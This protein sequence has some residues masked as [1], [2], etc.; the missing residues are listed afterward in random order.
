MGLRVLRCPPALRVVAI[1]ALALAAAVIG[2]PSATAGAA[3]DDNAAVNRYGGCLASQKAGDLLILVDESGSLKTS[4]AH[5]ARVDA[6][7]YLVKTLGGYADRTNSKLDV[8]IAG[9]SDGYTVRQDW[10]PLTGG[11]VDAVSDQVQNLAQHNSG[12]DTDYWLALDGARQTLAERAHNNPNR[13]QAIAWFS[14]GKIDFT[15]R[16]GGRPYAPGVDLGSAAGVS[17]M[18]RRATESICRP[19]GLADQLRSSHVVMLG[20]GLGEAAS[21]G[22]FDV[23]SAI[24]TGSGANGTKCGSISDPKPGAFYRVSNI[25]QMLFAFDALNPTPGL[26]DSKPVCHQNV[27]QEARHNFVLDRSVKSVNILGSGGMPSIVPYLISPSGQQLQL[28]KKDGSVDTNIDGMPV[29]Y[30]WQSESAQTVSLR[31]AA[32]PKWPGQWAI[33]YVDT[34]GQHPD[35]VSRV[36]V[37]I[38]TDIFPAL[39]DD[40]ASS[41]HAGQV[42]RAVSFGLVDGQGHPIDPNN[43]AG[44]AALSATLAVEGA[45]PVKL[46]DSVPK[47]AIGKPVDVDLTKVKPGP[48]T[49]RMSLVI[50]TAP[51]PDPHGGPPI[52]GTTLSPQ[53]VDKPVQILPKVGLPAPSQRIDFGT[54]QGTKGA[55]AKLDITGPGCV[56]IAGSDRPSI[57]AEPDSIGAVEVTSTATGPANCVKAGDGQKAGLPVTLRTQHDGH[58]GLS[59]KMPIHI[60]AKDN[61]ADV[62]VVDVTFAAS[63]VRSLSTTNFVLVFIAALLLGPGIPLALLYAGKWLAGKIPDVPML[64]ERIPVE[65]DNGVV[66]RDGQQLEMADTDLLTPVPGLAG[67]ARHLRVQGVELA[68]VL[69]RSPFG[70]AQVTLNAPG[71]V[72]AGSEVPSTDATGLRAVLPLAV[73]GK[74]VVLHDPRGPANRADV[75]LMVAGHADLAARK[76]IYEDIERRLPEL[77]SM[78]RQRAVEAQLTP[79]EA[80]ESEQP[81]PFGAAPTAQTSF[82]PFADS[83]VDQTPFT[84]GS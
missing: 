54:V 65:I 47:D 14:D 50:T 68:T 49:V 62:Q 45:A 38:T 5:A 33:V 63:M 13:C 27:C 83:H 11:S 22:D 37:H 42:K 3:P 46:V 48:A 67:G 30:Q 51:A 34:T 61:P 9:F 23:M 59:G 64:A 35:A 60:A 28:A 21:S 31:G 57:S 4:D 2:W 55:T 80:G 32:S 19:G 84:G 41:W 58:G 69:G 16:P 36:A 26:G 17:E 53:Q 18:V 6:A 12:A 29:S 76:K 81:S 44:E 39:K 66:L 77:L 10:R 43:I 1:A 7:K 20:V 24:T 40:P 71:Y 56:W 52:P 8:A 82:D 78:L 25:D 73:H 70:A 72:S 15:Q 74:W 75:L 79:T